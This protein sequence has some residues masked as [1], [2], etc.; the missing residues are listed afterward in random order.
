METENWTEEK[1][2][3]WMMAGNYP[4]GWPDMD[5]KELVTLHRQAFA[6]LSRDVQYQ[7]TVKRKVMIPALRRKGKTEREITKTIRKG[8]RVN[9]VMA[10]RMGDVGITTDLEAEYGYVVRINCIEG[11]MDV[12]GNGECVVPIMPE[13]A[14]IDIEPIEDPR[15]D[16]VKI[17]FPDA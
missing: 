16:K 13:G 2:W 3:N 12:F 1:L 10:S 5:R 15:P 14:L 17:A 9:V 4:P 11:E 8:T 7:A 6:T